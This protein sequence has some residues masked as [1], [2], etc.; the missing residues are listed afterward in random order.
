MAA[1]GVSVIALPQTNLYLQG[2]DLT[3]SVPRGLT[4]TR[5]L[6]AAGAN[7][8]AGGDNVRD[9][10][11]RGR[12]GRPVGDR[13][14]HGDGRPPHAGRGVARRRGRGPGGHGPARRPARSSAPAAEL[15]CVEGTDLVDAIARAGQTRTVVHAGRVVART[16]VR[17]SLLPKAGHRPATPSEE[18]P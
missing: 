1:A 18:T 4:A 8:A 15:L 16:V 11:Q 9:A 10:V 14:P 6:L 3:S 2:R 12:P 17:R 7:V 13:G 5:T